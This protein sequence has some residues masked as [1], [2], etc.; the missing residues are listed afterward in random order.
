MAAHAFV[1][2]L[3]RATAR[4]D[5]ARS[6]VETCGLPGE[7]WAA[8]DGAA[9]TPEEVAARVG[10]HLF[11]PPYPFA[12]R[13]GEIGCFLGH[14][15]IW[16]E[17]VRRDL[18]RALVIEDDVTLDARTF[19]RAL[20]LGLRN[21]DALGYVQLQDRPPRGPA[22]A[23]DREGPC[24]LTLPRITPLRTSAQLVSLDAARRLLA[25][26]HRID[27][28]VDSFI[29]AHW[30]TGLRPAAIWPS[31]V[32]TIAGALAGSTIQGGRRSLSERLWREGARLLYRRRVAR[33]S[34]RGAAPDPGAGQ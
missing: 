2:H 12:L 24:A 4:R 5:N 23:I 31:G 28:P 26:S 18:S 16:A 17:I 13:P 1:L 25:A 9:L 7:I 29:Q 10:A 6:L 33:A 34:G 8:V 15:A 20:A 11:A 21:V 14:R 19:A 22:R 30:H 3:T 32:S 27:R